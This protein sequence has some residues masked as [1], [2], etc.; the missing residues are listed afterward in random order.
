MV[1]WQIFER[2]QKKFVEGSMRC[3]S[4]KTCFSVIFPLMQHVTSQLQY[5][6]RTRPRKQNWPHIYFPFSLLLSI[7]DGFGYSTPVAAAPVIYCIGRWPFHDDNNRNRTMTPAK[8]TW[9][10]RIPRYHNK[11]PLLPGK[12]WNH[13]KFQLSDQYEVQRDRVI[14]HCVFVR[15]TWHLSGWDDHG[16]ISL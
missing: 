11:N 16:S 8:Q 2:R 1:S 10:A 9:A 15:Q 12:W 4:N 7:V 6:I 5:Q 3:T 13:I 14:Y